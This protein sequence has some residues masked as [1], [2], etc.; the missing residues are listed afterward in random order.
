VRAILLFGGFS[1]NINYEM[2]TGSFSVAGICRF[3][4][5]ISIY[6]E[7][8]TQLPTESMTIRR[9]SAA[10]QQIQNSKNGGGGDAL[11]AVWWHCR[12]LCGQRISY[13]YW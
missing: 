8:A 3:S 13:R 11:T 6:M 5:A 10:I 2:H 9:S 1:G 7:A 4:I 12:K